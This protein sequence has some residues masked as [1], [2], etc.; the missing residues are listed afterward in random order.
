MRFSGAHVSAGTP[1]SRYSHGT[2]FPNRSPRVTRRAMSTKHVRTTADLVRFSLNL[3]IECG[4]C[5]SSNILTGIEAVQ[6]GGAQ[7]S[8]AT[9]QRRL[10]CEHCGERAAKLRYLG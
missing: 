10:L 4:Q 1:Y 8:L 2:M 6:V 9:L 7:T 3:T 5:G